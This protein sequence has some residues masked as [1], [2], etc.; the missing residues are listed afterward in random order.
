MNTFSDNESPHKLVGQP[1]DMLVEITNRCNHQC[2][3]CAHH[4][5]QQKQ[6]EIDVRFLKRILYEA[7]EMGVHRVG[8]Y[9]T[10]E[11]FM[12]KEV[13][14]HIRNAKEIGYEYVYAD[15]NGALASKENLEKVMTAGLDSLKFSINAGKSD[16]YRFIHGHDDFNRVIDNLKLCHE[17]KK[18]INPRMKILV[19][20]IVTK[21]TAD[22]VEIL[23]RMT[24]PYVDAFIT[25]PVRWY[26]QQC[27]VD[28]SHLKMENSTTPN[29]PCDMVFDR[30]HVTYDG[31]LSAC[32]VDFNHDLLVADL[33]KTTL[34]EA[35]SS[36]NAVSLRKRHIHDQLEGTM[37][38]GCTRG[39][40]VPY[41]A[42]QIS[43]KYRQTKTITAME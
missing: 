39:R 38:Y 35:W 32:C 18:K 41:E 8:L 15:T 24:A 3:F 23:R 5:M 6:G 16:S 31:F 11:M 12:C 36:E 14:T 30:I 40:F 25:H 19:S 10:G 29:V 37:C 28:L 4:K 33:N 17:L 13:A 34:Y 1:K 42:L 2:I 22:E 21:K 9:T 20:F 7:Y 27:D 43:N 26:L